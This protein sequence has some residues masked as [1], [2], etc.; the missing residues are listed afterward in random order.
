MIS[1]NQLYWSN[2][3]VSGYK[4]SGK[5]QDPDMALINHFKNHIH[6][7]FR[8]FTDVLII[9]IQFLKNISLKFNT[10][11]SKLIVY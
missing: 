2:D 3:E 8:Y 5:Y 11:I 1:R 6:I 4:Q 7:G 9:I 10:I